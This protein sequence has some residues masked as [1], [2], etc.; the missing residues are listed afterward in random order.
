MT[1][2]GTVD[3]RQSGAL[4][5]TG[6]TVP[7][8][9]A[10]RARLTGF[11]HAELAIVRLVIADSAPLL[12]MF[13]GEPFLHEGFAGDLLVYAKA[14]PYRVDLGMVEVIR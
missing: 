6:G 1:G 12:I 3:R 8:V 2:A 4:R 10:V 7:A 11:D 9:R 13:E 5:G 14:R